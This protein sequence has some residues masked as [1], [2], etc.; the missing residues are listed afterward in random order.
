[1]RLDL[2]EGSSL[3]AFIFGDVLLNEVNS[4][5]GIRKMRGED[6]FASAFLTKFSEL[7]ESMLDES[8]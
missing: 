3:Q 5:E 4:I 8:P 6:E 7:P 2:S 1:M